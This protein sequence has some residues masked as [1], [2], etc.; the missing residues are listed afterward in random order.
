MIT[1]LDEKHFQT[2]FS[3]KS[4][5]KV[6]TL[7]KTKS[8]NQQN[9]SILSTF[10][11]VLATAVSEAKKPAIYKFKKGGRLLSKNVMKAIWQ[12]QDKCCYFSIFY[13]D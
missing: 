3:E 8:T 7:I 1:V 12:S 13:I 9:S 4:K 2:S 6:I 10:Q 11:L 5:K